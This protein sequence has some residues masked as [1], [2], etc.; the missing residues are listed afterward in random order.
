MRKLRPKEVKLTVAFQLVSDG[1]GIQIQLWPPFPISA[2]FSHLFRLFQWETWA[3][4]EGSLD[5]FYG[6][7]KAIL[8]EKEKE[9]TEPTLQSLRWCGRI[10]FSVLAAHQADASSEVKLGFCSFIFRF[11]NIGGLGV[12]EVGPG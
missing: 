5:Q 8:E 2:C 7:I 4:S 1:A 3:Y 10:R 12:W 6:N 9:K 11:K